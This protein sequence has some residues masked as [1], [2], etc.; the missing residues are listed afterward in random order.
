MAV[1]IVSIGDTEV[2]VEIKRPIHR[3]RPALTV[4]DYGVARLRELLHKAVHSMAPLIHGGY[5]T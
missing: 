5:V 2:S 1:L 4:A 3:R